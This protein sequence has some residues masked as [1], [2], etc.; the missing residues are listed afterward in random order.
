MDSLELCSVVTLDTTTRPLLSLF[1]CPS[2]KR[3][4]T[5]HK[6][7][8][9]EAEAA[10]A[11]V[12]KPFFLQK[13]WA[14]CVPSCFV[15]CIHTNLCSKCVQSNYI[16][17]VFWRNFVSASIS[18]VSIQIHM[19]ILFRIVVTFV[20]AV[21]VYI[22][23]P[24]AATAAMAIQIY[25]QFSGKQITQWYGKHHCAKNRCEWEK[26]EQNNH[27]I[28]IPLNDKTHI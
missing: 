8:K 17:F 5:A 10:T 28:R 24:E 15:L 1:I 21:C 7:K 6:R 2:Y 9:S 12:N 26:R 18:C 25:S 14:C 13:Q 22:R 19:A 27:R 3:V 20:V 23:K 11:V 16:I 4:H